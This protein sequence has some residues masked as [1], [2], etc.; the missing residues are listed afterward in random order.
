MEV[1]VDRGQRGKQLQLQVELKVELIIGKG[2]NIHVISFFKKERNYTTPQESQF[3]HDLLFLS[4][5]AS[6]CATVLK[7]KDNN[8]LFCPTRFTAESCS[9]FGHNVNNYSYRKAHPLGESQ[10][11]SWMVLWAY[12]LHYWNNTLPES[13]KVNPRYLTNWAA[14]ILLVVPVMH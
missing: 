12:S 1:L 2:E 9:S 6:S 5:Y 13:P 8:I 10:P 11:D 14:T 4:S 7:L 3:D